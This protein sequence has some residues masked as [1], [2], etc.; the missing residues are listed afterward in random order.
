MK[1]VILAPLRN[2]DAERQALWQRARPTWEVFGWPI[3]TAPGPEEGPFNRSA[4]INQAARLAGD[5]DVA[6]IIDSDVIAHPQAVRDAVDIAHALGRMVLPHTERFMLTPM[7]TRKVLSGFEPQE[8][9]SSRNVTNI[10][11]DSVSC[12]QAI[13]RHLWDVVGGFDERFVGWG[14]E[15]SA[16]EMATTVMGGPTIRLGSV[17][18]HLHHTRPKDSDRKTPTRQANI[19]RMERYRDARTRADIEALM[20]DEKVSTAMPT[21]SSTIPRIFHRTVPAKTSP[22]VEMWWEGFQVMHPGWEFR[23][24]AEPLKPADFPLT[25]THWKHCTSGAQKAGLV[26]LELLVTHGG[27][28]VDSDVECFTSFEPLVNLDAFAAWEDER[29]V[30]DAILGAKPGHPVFIEMLDSALRIIE[31]GPGFGRN[32]QQFAWRSGPGVT[33]SHLPGRRDVTLFPPGTFYQIHYLHKANLDNPPLPWEMARHHW[34]GSWLT[35]EQRQ[36][37]DKRQRA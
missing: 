1:V 20:N 37:Q 26:R 4:A 24:W 29:C 7:A 23:T 25:A 36:S 13:P 17:L 22:L 30:P 31:Q 21:T 35:P 9:R 16:F 2:L 33:T 15:D 14:H 5:W 12:A 19:A 10:F 28:Y 3:F 8:D 27:V 6:L 32:A 11:R 34:H 18:Y